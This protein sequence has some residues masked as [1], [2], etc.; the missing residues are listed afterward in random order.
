[1]QCLTIHIP[2]HATS[3]APVVIICV[4]FVSVQ[5]MLYVFVTEDRRTVVRQPWL[6]HPGAVGA[7]A[8]AS[9]AVPEAAGEVQAD[10][11]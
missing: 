1:M 8:T 5:I 6:C 4:H 9:E 10:C 3:S 11:A 2:A 7:Q